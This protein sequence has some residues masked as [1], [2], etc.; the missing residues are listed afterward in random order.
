MYMYM[1]QVDDAI[2]LLDRGDL[3]HR[4]KLLSDTHI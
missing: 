3:E 1:Y 4:L 2:E